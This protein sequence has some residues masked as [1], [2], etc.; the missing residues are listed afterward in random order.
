MIIQGGYLEG[1]IFQLEGTMEEVMGEATLGALP[2][3]PAVM[4]AIALGGYCNDDAPFYYGKVGPF[5]Y[6]VS[7]EDLYG[8]R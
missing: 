5:G 1:Q 8:T 7:Q 4:Q 2:G 3:N 6:V